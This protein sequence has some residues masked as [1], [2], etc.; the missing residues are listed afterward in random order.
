[1]KKFVL[2]GKTISDG[3]EV[4]NF[5]GF[6]PG[7]GFKLTEFEIYPS[8]LNRQQELCATI[9]AGKTSH[10]PATPNFQ[11]EGLIASA[12]YLLW[13]APSYGSSTPR[14]VINHEFIITQNLILTVKDYE[15]GGSD[16]EINWQCTFEPVKMSK[17]E[18]AVTNYK[19]F[20]ISDD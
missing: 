5:S 3:T 16:N 2:R 19:Q 14:T 12:L 11:D 4:L 20:M 6:K 17:S 15:S 18:E 7:M 8:D 1:M 9:T 13:N 10:N